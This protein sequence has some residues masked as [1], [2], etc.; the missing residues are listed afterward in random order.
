MHTY[1]YYHKIKFKKID[2]KKLPLLMHKQCI[3]NF[4]NTIVS[5]IVFISLKLSLIILTSCCKKN[6][7]MKKSSIKRSHIRDVAC[8]VLRRSSSRNGNIRNDVD[9]KDKKFLFFLS[10]TK[11]KIV[12][13]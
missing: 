9:R 1:F 12:T 7:L 11:G 4:F 10:T 8:A 5:N 3:L 13:T 2:S 6:I